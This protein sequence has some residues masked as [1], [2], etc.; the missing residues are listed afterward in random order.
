MS[1]DNMSPYVN[2]E[3]HRR[4][5]RLRGYDYSQ[6]G[7]YF[8]TMVTQ[9]RKNLFGKIV[10]GSLVLIDAGNIAADCWLQIAELSF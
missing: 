6:A 4:S 2:L 9:D 5:I 1:Q 3:N 7:A 8:V 10:G